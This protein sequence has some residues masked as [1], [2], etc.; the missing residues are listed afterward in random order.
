MSIFTH[1]ATRTTTVCRCWAVR[2]GDGVTLGFTDHDMSLSFGGIEFRADSGLTAR[3]FEQST[4]LSVDNSEAIGA[5]SDSAI[6]EEDIE[7]GRF[8]DASVTMWLVN[9]RDPSERM[10]RFAGRIGEIVRSGETFRAELRGL[11]EGLNKPQGFVYQRTC[12]AILGDRRCRVNLDQS[13]FRAQVN[14]DRVAD[15]KTFTFDTFPDFKNG[16]FQNGVVTVLSGAA[17]GLSAHVKVDRVAGA[18]RRIV[19][20]QGI[21]ARVAPG[22]QISLLAGCDKQSDTCKAKFDNFLNFRGFPSI[23]GEDWLMAYPTDRIPND[24]GK[25]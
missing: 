21:Q 13:S 11:T 17:K 1:L 16:W 3:A 23:P 20:W 2:R 8:D 22:D 9:W 4:G 10:V 19:L 7:A 6:R 5:L 18:G 24:G 12:S 15:S 25:L 14:V